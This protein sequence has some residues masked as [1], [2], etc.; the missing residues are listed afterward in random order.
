MSEKAN[1]VFDLVVT[2]IESSPSLYKVTLSLKVCY[3]KDIGCQTLTL[4]EEVTLVRPSCPTGRRR[5]KR[6]MDM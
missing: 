2:V 3:I 6:A 4:A 1:D 5:K